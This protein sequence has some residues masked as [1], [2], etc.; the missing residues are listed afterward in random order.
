MTVAIYAYSGK[1]DAYKFLPA[2]SSPAVLEAGL[3][4]A[5]QI[6]RCIYTPG[7]IFS[8]RVRGRGLLLSSMTSLIN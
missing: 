2:W 5:G 3:T 7:R 4:L 1:K 6:K 8:A